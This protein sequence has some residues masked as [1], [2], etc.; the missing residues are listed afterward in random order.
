MQQYRLGTRWIESSFMEETWGSCKTASWTWVG[1]QP[2]QRSRPTVLRS[3]FCRREVRSSEEVISA[4]CLAL[5]RPRLEYCVPFW[6][7]QYGPRSKAYTVWGEAER[8]ELDSLKKRKLSENLAAVY[9]YLQDNGIRQSQA[10]WKHKSQWTQI[11]TICTIE[12]EAL[13]WCGRSIPRR[14]S[15]LDWKRHPILVLKL[16]LLWVGE[17]GKMISKGPFKRKLLY[18]FT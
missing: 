18:D 11:A 10:Q 8:N 6:D 5:R 12:S 2:L 17:L 7:N 14:Y 13:R 4:L 9:N 3:S 1:N 15:K 16:L